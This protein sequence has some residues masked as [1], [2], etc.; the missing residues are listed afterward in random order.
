M[1]LSSWHVWHLRINEESWGVRGMITSTTG[2]S[3]CPRRSQFV[4]NRLVILATDVVQTQGRILLRMLVVLMKKKKKMKK[5]QWKEWNSKRR[6]KTY[7]EAESAFQP[8]R[9]LF[10]FVDRE[11]VEQRRDTIVLKQQ[12]QQ[13]VI[14]LLAEI[15]N[16]RLLG[17]LLQPLGT[18]IESICYRWLL[19]FLLLLFGF[20]ASFQ[21]LFLLAVRRLLRHFRPEGR[22]SGSAD[23]PPSLRFDRASV[24]LRLH[25]CLQIEWQEEMN[26]A[27]RTRPRLIQWIWKKATIYIWIY[28]SDQ[29]LQLIDR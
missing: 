4:L 27:R 22:R 3:R 24:R 25:S 17:H 18:P 29:H 1:T 26:E 13:S 16:K 23:W 8:S 6:K 21:R 7:F 15:A 2:C 14:V 11:T 20:L 5:N 28:E 10:S 12:R 9:P 19:L